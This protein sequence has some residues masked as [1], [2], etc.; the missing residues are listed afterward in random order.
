MRHPLLNGAGRLVG[1]DNTDP[2]NC[3]ELRQLENFSAILRG[4]LLSSAVLFTLLRMADV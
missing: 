4:M 1:H 3:P 2:K